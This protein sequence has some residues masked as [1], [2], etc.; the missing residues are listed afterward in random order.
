[1]ENIVYVTR[2]KE[3]ALGLAEGTPGYFIITNI[4][5]FVKEGTQL[6][7]HELLSLPETVDFFAKLDNPK[8]LVFKNTP[9]IERICADRGWQLLN[10][11]AELSARVEEKI[12]QIAWLGELERFMPPPGYAG[13]HR[14]TVVKD[15]SWDGTP[16][17]LQFNHAH[18]GLGTLHIKT[19]E[20]LRR[21]Q[22]QFPDRPVRVTEFISGPV[23][24]N[25]NVVASDA[26]LVG[27]INYQ[28]TGLAPFTDNPFSTIGNDWEFAKRHLT[29]DQKTAYREIATLIGEKLREDG[30]KGLFG[31]D[32]IV[33]EQSGKVYL[34]EINARQPASTTYE[35]QLQRAS[36]QNL[37]SRMTTFEAHIAALLG[38]SLAGRSLISID[39]GAQIF[40]RN[41]K[42]DI[43]RRIQVSE[44]LMA[45]HG[46]LN[47]RGRQIAEMVK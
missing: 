8:I 12:S 39:D 13:R 29:S 32:V 27:N 20:D 25:N 15:I 31:I 24:T 3:R 45:A 35:S 21:V 19:P 37:E 7:T 23:F 6:D 40:F 38:Q 33:D 46:V 14:V 44:S 17:I 9:R 18:T 34:I 16:F 1:M 11:S 2:E 5:P 4:L 42:Q 47:E 26:T 28:I 30:W 22:E 43:V 36:G 41:S 10:P